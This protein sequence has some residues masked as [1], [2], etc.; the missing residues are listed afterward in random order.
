LLRN[1]QPLISAS[2]PQGCSKSCTR[3]V[4]IDRDIFRKKHGLAMSG[5]EGE[6][7]WTTK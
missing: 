6:K 2:H 5:K 1:P 4:E 3:E 7:Q